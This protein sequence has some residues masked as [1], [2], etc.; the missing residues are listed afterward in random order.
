MN[1]FNTIITR[2][3]EKLKLTKQELADKIYVS[4]KDVN[5]WERGISYPDISKLR[6]ICNVLKID[7]D[8]ILNASDINAIDDEGYGKS[9][10]HKYKKEMITTF[11]LALVGLLNSIVSIILDN[12]YNIL[13]LNLNII[14]GFFIILF[15]VFLFLRFAISFRHYYMYKKES[16]RYDKIFFKFFVS[17]LQF[18]ILTTLTIIIWIKNINIFVYLILIGV[19]FISIFISQSVMKVA[20]VKAKEDIVNIIM[21]ILSLSLILYTIVLIFVNRML[22]RPILISFLMSYVTYYIRIFRYDYFKK[23]Y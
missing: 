11:F 16:K 21:L 19:Y 13:I 9:I 2:K 15:S 23:L 12:K 18:F 1:C 4:L 22:F 14:F 6:I 5:E 3:R 17:Y 8:E 10:I 7:V 20:N